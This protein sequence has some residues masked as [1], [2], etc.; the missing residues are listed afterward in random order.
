MIDRRQFLAALAAWGT[1]SRLSAQTTLPHGELFRAGLV[2]EPGPTGRC[3]E[4]RLGGPVIRW[5]DARARWRMWYYGRSADFPQGLAPEF[6]TES[7]ATA[8]SEDGIR[9]TR[10][11][12]PLAGGAVLT[13]NPDPQAFDSVHVATGD[14]IRHGDEWLMVYFGGNQEMP[15]GTPPNYRYKGYRL[16]IGLAKSRDGL[17]WTRVPGNRTGGAII[18]VRD[19]DIYSAFPSLLH[20][21]ERFLVHYT[22]VD[23]LGRYWRSRIAASADGARWEYLSDLKWDHEAMLFEAGGIITR[24]PMANP[25]ADGPPWLMLYTAKDGRAEAGARRSIG[26]AVSDDAIT[27]RRLY[28]APIFTVGIEGAWDHAGVAVPRLTVTDAGWLLHYYGWSDRTFAEHPQRGIG[29]AIS[30]SGDLRKFRRVPYAA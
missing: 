13:P 30:A 24:S 25:V 28:D 18:D 7:I 12:G 17:N 20:D 22:S 29:C 23:K 15:T 4:T 21:G 27:W 14:V 9:W 1:A 2:L 5:D 11:D 3:D 8:V 19:D 10:E 16:R 6:G 26:A